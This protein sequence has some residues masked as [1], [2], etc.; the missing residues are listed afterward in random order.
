M[1]KDYP[2]LM[3]FRYLFYLFGTCGFLGSIAGMIIGI[4]E[5]D[6]LILGS[7]LFVF[8]IAILL[9]IFIRNV[10]RNSSNRFR[11]IP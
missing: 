8:I 5:N 9:G 4:V 3:R 11:N 10:V 6:I 2:Q 1:T 7:S